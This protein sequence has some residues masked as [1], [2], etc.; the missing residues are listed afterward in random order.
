MADMSFYVVSGTMA[1]NCMAS[2][3]DLHG[4]EVHGR[5]HEIVRGN[6]DFRFLKFLIA[7]VKEQEPGT[8]ITKYKISSPFLGHPL[9]RP[10]LSLRRP[11]PPCHFAAGRLPSYAG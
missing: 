11:D 5:G 3:A 8:A 1:L 2:V 4:V 6:F 7:A 9:P 10:S